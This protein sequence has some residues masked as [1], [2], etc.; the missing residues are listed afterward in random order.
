MENEFGKVVTLRKQGSFDAAHRLLKYKGKCNQL[1]GHTWKWDLII[2][3]TLGDDASGIFVDFAEIK[4]MMNMFDHCVVLNT[5]DPLA[6]VLPERTDGV[7]MFPNEPTCEFLTWWF[8]LRL[9]KE[10]RVNG[11]ILEI[12]LTL[13]ETETSSCTR[14]Y[15][16]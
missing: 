16:K 14:H 12:H 9:A 4:D 2:V 3:G 15:T 11:D 10:L 1:H 6:N 5:S 8:I 7:V 13:W